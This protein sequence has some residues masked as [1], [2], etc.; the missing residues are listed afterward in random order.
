MSGQDLGPI[1]GRPVCNMIYQTASAFLQLE[2]GPRG[3]GYRCT[4]T[5]L[6]RYQGVCTPPMVSDFTCFV[7]SSV[8]SS[9]SCPDYSLVAHPSMVPN[10]AGIVGRLS[11]LTVAGATDNSSFSQLCGPC[12]GAAPQLVAWMVSGK[13]SELEKFQIELSTSSSAP[14]G[15]K[16]TQITIHHGDHGKAGVPHEVFVPFRQIFQMC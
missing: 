1:A 9:N 3:R 8:R 14:G 6:V 7:E 11:N 15:R 5:E 4:D 13:D 16:P 2:A 10:T 12:T